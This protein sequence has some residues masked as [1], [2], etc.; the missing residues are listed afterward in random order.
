[1]SKLAINGLGR[2]GRHVLRQ[3]VTRAPEVEVVAVNDLTDAA[4]LAHLLMYDSVQGQASFSI[5]SEGTDLVLNGRRIPVFSEKEPERIPFSDRGATVV[6]ECTGRFTKRAQAAIHLRGSV[7]HVL[8]SAPAKDADFTVVMGVNDQA[9]DLARHL[10]IS[11]ASCT[12]NCLAPL[13]KV[14]DDAFGIEH[15]LMTTVHSY[16]NDQRILD[17]PHSDL[18]RARAAALN[19]IPTETGAA[20]AIGLVLPHLKGKLDGIAIRVPTPDVS[21]VDLTAQL[22]SDATRETFDAAFQ[23]AASAG[24]LA[25]YLVV[26][27]KEL[28][29]SDFIGN[30]ASTLYDPFLTR[31]MGPRM[32]KAFAWYDNEFGYASRLTDLTLKVLSGR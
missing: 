19:M 10:I 13:V 25:P 4:T 8:I 1:M 31:M 26:L 3:L 6:L 24:P 28:V 14:V 23:A 32:V 2:I 12:T 11:N 18:R 5:T 7:G 15:G 22:K 9:M 27:D 21:I 17:L 30:P 20:K 29:S 16:T